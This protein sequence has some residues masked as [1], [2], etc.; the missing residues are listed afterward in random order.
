MKQ[1]YF[2][3]YKKNKSELESLE[4]VLD[5]LKAKREGI[6]IV[7]GKVSKSADEF[8]Y[9]EQR[10][11][12]E[13]REP[14]ASEQVEQRIWKKEARKRELEYQIRVVERFIDEMPE[15]RDKDV[16]EML[17]LDGMTQN[18]IGRITGYTQ[19]MI[20]RII[21]GCSKDS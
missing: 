20:S 11:T 10:V 12:V 9:I 4:K 16:M 21:S 3:N 19:S 13:M 14:R 17:Y 7:A 1:E 5:K 15:G 8:P 6:P 2:K 18:E